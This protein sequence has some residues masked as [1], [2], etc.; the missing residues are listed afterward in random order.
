MI[1][2]ILLENMSNGALLILLYNALAFGLQPLAGL[3]LD[4]AD[5]AKRGASLALLLSALGLAFFSH[6]LQI[7]M[8]CAGLGSAFFHPGAGGTAIKHTPNRASGPGIFAAFGVIGLAIGAQLSLFASN[9]AQI[10]FIVALLILA[11]A[12]WFF[13]Q[14]KS[15]STPPSETTL[16]PDTW[17]LILLVGMALRS[18]VWVASKSEIADATMSALWVALAAGTGKLFGGFLSDRIGWGRWTVIALLASIPLLA[19]RAN[20]IIL[21]CA[22]V[23]LLQSITGLT[24]AWLGQRLPGSPSMAAGLGLGLAV[25]VGGVP[26]LLVASER[27]TGTTAIVMTLV[28]SLIL[29][30]LPLAK[31]PGSM[32]RT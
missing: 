32:E 24:L 16:M 20:E 28:V 9:F 15:V 17:V 18:F 12:I 11:L 6:S 10:G 30:W 27:L 5:F 26:I 25:I 7:A 31:H 3:V 8:L 21:L 29:H 1:T 23:F 13:P 2:R 19:F 22:G 14:G 4:R